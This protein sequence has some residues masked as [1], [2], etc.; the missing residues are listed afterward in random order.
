M[1]KLK[2]I[3]KLTNKVDPASLV[4]SKSSEFLRE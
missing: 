1:N 2:E 3:N 4:K